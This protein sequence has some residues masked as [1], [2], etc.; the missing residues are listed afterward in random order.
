MKR[1][2]FL[3]VFGIWVSFP[4]FFFFRIIE[5]FIIN[6]G[7][8]A[9]PPSMEQLSWIPNDRDFV[10]IAVQECNY[11][12]TEK[13]F[14]I[15]IAVEHFVFLVQN[16]LGNDFENV[17]MCTSDSSSSFLFV[18]NTKLAHMNSV[19][20]SFTF[21]SNLFS[22]LKTTLRLLD[23]SKKFIPQDLCVNEKFLEPTKKS[24]LLDKV[25]KVFLITYF[26]SDFQK[27]KN[28]SNHLSSWR[29]FILLCEF[30]S[31]WR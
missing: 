28:C 22:Q 20:V 2:Y 17:A 19:R 8:I 16:R 7:G 25:N 21:S 11:K 4:L 12:V 24:F 29:Y 31:R 6:K 18:K 1:D 23:C 26:Q 9:T 3:L 10:L 5:S 14:G 30:N 27:K 15:A 13:E